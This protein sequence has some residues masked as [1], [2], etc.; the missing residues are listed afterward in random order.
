MCK[1]NGPMTQQ[2]SGALLTGLLIKMLRT[3]WNQENRIKFLNLALKN[4]TFIT[5]N[6]LKKDGSLFRCAKGKVGYGSAFLDDYAF[7]IDAFIHLF[8]VGSENKFLELA[9]ELTEHCF[10]NFYSE[11][12]N[13]FYYSP[14]NGEALIAKNF[15]VSDNVIPAS[16]SQMAYNLQMLY[17]LT[18]T[19]K[20]NATSGKMLKQLQNEIKSAPSSHSNWGLAA[21][22][23]N[24]NFYE[25]CI[26]GKAVDDLRAGFAKH[27]Q[28]NANFVY[29]K[30][31]S[32]IALLKGRYPAN[33]TLIYVCT[34]NA[35]KAPVKTIA[36][37]LEQMQ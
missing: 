26:V 23:N 18:G 31:A 28:P 6:L 4:A 16:N 7:I 24:F 37:A 10:E 1:E 36:E 5:D 35:C 21:L 3:N 32:E 34:N 13:L 20:Y 11:E 14:Q 2:T 15:E 9:I 27:Y 12:K 25:V 8:S 29:S 19:A 17:A 33:E 30:T 22:R